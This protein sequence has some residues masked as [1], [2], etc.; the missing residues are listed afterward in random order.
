MKRGRPSDESIDRALIESARAEFDERGCHAMSMES[1]AV[2][3]GVSKVSLYRRWP[4]KSAIIAELFGL[5][6]EESSTEDRGSL[7][8]DIRALLERFMLSSGAASAGRIVMRTVGEIAG[9]PELLAL[10]REKLFAPRI[11]QMRVIVKRAQA[12]GELRPGLPTDI[13]CAMVAGPLFLYYLTVLAGSEV[14][15]T[16]DP[17]GQLTRAIRDGISK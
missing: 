7:E 6:G 12:R 4:S 2:R 9:D 13:A 15:L 10:Y 17:V 8:A 11:E 3:A 14:E 5:M 1:I 16:S